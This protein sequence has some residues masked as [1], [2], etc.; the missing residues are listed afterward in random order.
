[1]S[2]HEE[3]DVTTGEPQPTFSD[4]TWPVWSVEQHDSTFVTLE[5]NNLEDVFSKI[6]KQLVYLFI[7]ELTMPLIVVI[8]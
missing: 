8:L 7:F 6:N 4:K 1:M 2:S 5:G 3:K